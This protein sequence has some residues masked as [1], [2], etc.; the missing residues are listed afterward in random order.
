MTMSEL[1]DEIV[2]I[3]RL[4]R[5]GEDLP[6]LLKMLGLK[7]WPKQREI[8]E[9]FY[10]RNFKELVICA[11]MRSGKSFLAAVI[12]HIE[13]IRYLALFDPWKHYGIVPGAPTHGFLTAVS[14][15]QAKRL[16]F[17]YYKAILEAAPIYQH[18]NFEKD[19][20]KVVFPENNLTVQAI[21]CSSASAA[22][23]TLLFAIMDELARFCDTEGNASSDLVYDTLSRGCKTLGG[24]VVSIS[25][26]LYASDKVMRLLDD[27]RAENEYSASR[28]QAPSMLGY[29]LSTW[30][31]NPNLK[32]ISFDREF[33]LNPEAA[34]RDW[35]AVPSH[36]IEPYFREPSRIDLALDIRRKNPRVTEDGRVEGL[37]PNTPMKYYLHG[38]P[39]FKNDSFGLCLAHLDK[40]R[41]WVDMLWR[42]VPTGPAHEID[43]ALVRRVIENIDKIV[44]IRKVTF[45]TWNFPE[46][47]QA[48][49]KR[50][51]EVENL[52][53][54][55]EQYDRLKE[56]IYSDPPAILIP[57]HE[58][59]V[60]DSRMPK[61]VT[62]ELKQLELV[63][64]KKVDHPYGGSKDVADALAGAAWTV[65]ATKN[66]RRFRELR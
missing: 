33:T 53:I 24:K 43:A 1:T 56:G 63:K 3:A 27:V 4:V 61:T 34:G 26:P 62:I 49:R 13:T 66:T 21:P 16:V 64:G 57:V 51:I 52:L 55:K 5:A 65:N 41:V 19:T 2:N 50:N 39:S 32:R 58:L 9:T 12:G 54:G 46:T 17:S 47:V 45:D 11:G 20:L 44:G 22:G 60:Q 18:I 10:S 48:L 25:S 7:L 40:E 36:S 38:D 6:Y 30:E 35:G 59:Q 42:F 14:E 23:G 15:G 37:I 28:N 8:I 29:H 31:I